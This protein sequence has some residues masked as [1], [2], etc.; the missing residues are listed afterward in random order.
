MIGDGG[1][2]AVDLLVVEEILIAAGGG[3]FFADNFLGKRVAAIVEI[4]GGHAFD[5]G[6]LDGV[7]EQAGALHADTDDA[8]A[9]TVARSRHLPGQRVVLRFQKNR[10]HS[11]Q[12]ASS[13]GTALQEFAAGK[14]FF[15]D[16]L[17]KRVDSRKSSANS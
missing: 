1:D 12:R 11:R 16:A 5:T 9:N 7:A 3:D 14:I 17:L 6:Q 2:E 8:E 4:A 15:H 13:A 10:R